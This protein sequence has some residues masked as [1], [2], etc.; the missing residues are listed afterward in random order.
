VADVLFDVD[1]TLAP[2][3]PALAPRL[4]WMQAT[5][6]GIGPFVRQ[7]GLDGSGIRITTAAGIHAVPLA[8]HALLSLLYF[9]KDVP[10]RRRDQ[11]AHCWERTCGRKLRF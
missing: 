8:E 6:S 11:R 4:R 3:L 7:N 10:A 5:S 9:V 2:Q 1:R